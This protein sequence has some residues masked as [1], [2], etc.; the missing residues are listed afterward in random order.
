[1]ADSRPAPGSRT[2]LVRHPERGSY[3]RDTACAILDE[4][5][6][7]HVGFA[8]D[9]GPMVIPTLFARLDDTIYLHGSAIGRMLTTL[10]GGVDMC[11][12]VT[13]VDGLVLARSA[14][15]HSMNYRSVV[16]LG[17]GREVTDP[18]EKWRALEATVNHVLAKRWDAVRQ[19]SDAELR[20][21]TVVALPIE[22]YSVKIRAGGVVDSESDYG[23]DAWAGVLPLAVTAGEPEPDARL[24]PGIQVPDE[25]R[26]YRRG[27][28]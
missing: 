21:T 5:L 8:T 18:D 23:L 28:R 11:V 20:A 19:P 16:V 13:L 10:A 3:D 15:H 24:A 14:F 22:E 27:R 2:R 9:G 6:V 12:T 4:A 1:M 25:V 17:R 26:R 7:C